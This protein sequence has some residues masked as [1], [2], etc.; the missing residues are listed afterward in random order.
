MKQKQQFRTY[1][2]S[3]TPTQREAYAARC[4]TTVGYLY[5]IAGGHSRASG[6]LARVLAEQSGHCV[7]PR[8]IRADIFGEPDD[9]PSLVIRTLMRI[10]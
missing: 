10:G 8:S 1:L 2:R 3:L 9:L 4:R 6:P 7:D 5:Q